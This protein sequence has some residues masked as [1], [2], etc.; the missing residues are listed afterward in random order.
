MP[1]L[2]LD[3]GAPAYCRGE[4]CGALCA[5]I[6]STEQ[7]RITDLIIELEN[8]SKTNV[9]V[10][11]ALVEDTN[12]DGVFFSISAEELGTYPEYEPESRREDMSQ[13]DFSYEFLSEIDQPDEPL[14]VEAEQRLRD[15]AADHNDIIGASVAVEE[16]TGAETPHRFQTRIVVYMRPSNVVAV[17][18]APD[19][20]T[21][22]QQTLSTVER[23]VREKRTRLRERWKQP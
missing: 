10:P 21:S 14:R 4:L 18:K 19:A 6:T 13:T 17:E 11:V 5:I 9:T 2:E 12:D 7:H 23:Q 15:L 16:L 3:S 8:P 20:I 22:V 1:T